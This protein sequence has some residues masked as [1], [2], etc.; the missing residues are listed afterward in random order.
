MQDHR[1]KFKAIPKRFHPNGLTILYED[2]DILVIDKTSGLL[3]TGTAKI[4]E[5]TAYF[6]LTD[7]VRKGN[8]KS[9]N[10]IYLVH[11]LDRDTSG[12]IIFTKTEKA[13]QFLQEEWKNFS[14][15]Y[16]A[17]VDGEPPQQMGE[18]T[19]YL[20][21]N[22][23]HKVYST[24]DTDKGKLSTAAYQVMGRSKRYSLLEVTLH[25]GRKNQ[26]RAHFSEGGFPIAGDKTYGDAGKTAN[27]LMLHSISLTIKHP[28]TQKEMVF[29]SDP[30]V[31]FNTLV[32]P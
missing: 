14:K 20:K 7:Y 32:S 27:R 3:T 28:Y 11:R 24:K 31:Y 2:H 16:M 15:K 4:K 12:V 10:R 21:E 30:P 5:K 23:M 13:Q 6:L 19:S 18:I 8:S 25:T 9:K 26:I 1:K 17:I 29:K 22:K